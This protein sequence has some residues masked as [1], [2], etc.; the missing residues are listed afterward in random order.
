MTDDPLDAVAAAIA[1]GTP[2]DWQAAFTAARTDEDR[3]A[4][5]HL[6]RIAEYG[7]ARA[8][9]RPAPDDG[10]NEPA[11]EI[12]GTL[13][14]R[15]R[16]GRG[17][18]GDVYRAWDPALHRDVALKLL[19]SRVSADSAAVVDEGRLMARVRH[20]NVVTIYGAQR[21]DERVGLWMEFIEGHTL[22]DELRERGPLDA[23]EVAAI[24]VALARALAAVHDTGLLHRDIKPSNVIRENTG[25]IVLG[26]FG[27]G[28]EVDQ[29]E[30]ERVGLTGTPAYLAPEVFAH[31]PATP[32]SDLY[33]LGAILFHLL[34]GKHPVPGSTIGEIRLAHQRGTRLQLRELRK[35]LPSR[36]LQTIERALE[37]D[38]AIRFADARAM[39]KA[40]AASLP[41]AG[42]RR[43]RRMVFAGA[44]VVIAAG[45][46]VAVLNWPSA[47]VVLLVDPKLTAAFNIRAPAL[48]GRTAACTARNNGG[49]A[50]CDLRAGTG[51]VL[52]APSPGEGRALDALLS[53]DGQSMAYLWQDR[54]LTLRVIGIDGMGDREVY[55]VGHRNMLLSTWSP[56]SRAVTVAVTESPS[57]RYVIAP[58]DGSTP[59][60]DLVRFRTPSGESDLSADLRFVA[61]ARRPSSGAGHTDLYVLDVATGRES[62][63]SPHPANDET[64]MWTPDGRGL[65][66]LSARTGVNAVHYQPMTNGVGTG[67]SSQI[68]SAERSELF[69]QGVTGD[70]TLFVQRVGPW[71]TIFTADVDFSAGTIA[72]AVR[73][74]PG[75]H[76]Q[77][78]GPSWSPDGSKVAYLSGPVGVS[79][80]GHR[81]TVR[82][83]N[84]RTD[85]EYPVHGTAER[86]RRARWSPDG[87][88][89]AVTSNAGGNGRTQVLEVFDLASP[90]SPQRIVEGVAIRDFHWDPRPGA[91]AIIYME[92]NA[93]PGPPPRLMRI[94]LISGQTTVVADSASDEHLNEYSDFAVA[95]EDG[96]LAFSMVPPPALARLGRPGVLRLRYPDRA[97]DHPWRIAPYAM[98]WS[99]DGRALLIYGSSA[100][101]RGFW[102]VDALSGQV[103]RLSADTDTV[104]SMDLG[105]DG[106]SLVFAAGS[107]EPQMLMLS[108][109]R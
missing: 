4:L 84:T 29:S 74:D 42:R 48:D 38:P 106:L 63:I 53:P 96:S 46:A 15:E 86:G 88:R 83:V 87:T 94:D 60:R 93:P 55:R 34:T 28:Q 85:R 95:H 103:R 52:R 7:S 11:P 40:L 91:P 69:L 2:P 89:I 1:D 23:A 79:S 33:S 21:I 44:L 75:S 6:R 25:R 12:W 66:F 64:P 108:G 76:D 62:P 27:T 90:E 45:I 107:P 77:H 22:A 71:P 26:D 37:R 50:I 35:D 58:I 98:T 18:F 99:R 19:H 32:R 78:N 51:K 56:D 16:V 97:V 104:T 31:A 13:Q 70:G 82:D 10:E 8:G 92:Y 59:A 49:V 67:E 43:R 105:R 102:M 20:P 30:S 80:S 81:L 41:D 47:P 39:E 5:E 54:E 24:G 3:A 73:L 109:F 36:L 65:I 17:R 68:Y 72:P 14:V 9:D 100:G 57:R 61:L 101:E